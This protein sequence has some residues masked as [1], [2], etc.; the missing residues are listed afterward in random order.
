[1]ADGDGHGAAE[2]SDGQAIL[3]VVVSFALFL[4]VPSAIAQGFEV[5]QDDSATQ[6]LLRI[7]GVLLVVAY[8]LA[9][10]RVLSLE[11]RAVRPLLTYGGFLLIW[12]P[13][14]MYLYPYVVRAFGL[15]LPAQQ[16]LA[17]LATADRDALFWVVV[18]MACVGSPIAEE[19]FFRGF[20]FNAVTK[21]YSPKVAV[22][23]TS[24]LFGAVHE[25]SVALPITFLGVLFGYFRL[26]TGGVGSSILLHIVHNTWTVVLILSFPSFMDAVFDPK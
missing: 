18:F 24:V 7:V 2:L 5:A 17:F 9:R 10:R 23:V 22:A 1:M 19:L 26:K 6:G 14:A 13:C 20:L 8:A 11:F 21:F 16:A 12:F 3:D 4:L 15:E 25:P